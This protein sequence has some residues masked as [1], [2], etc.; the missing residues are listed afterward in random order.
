MAENTTTYTWTEWDKAMTEAFFKQQ[1]QDNTALNNA[2]NE[3]TQTGT[4]SKADE[5]AFDTFRGTYWTNASTVSQVTPATSTTSATPQPVITEVKPTTTA[6]QAIQDQA[7]AQAKLEAERTAQE[8]ARIAEQK[9]TA[10]AAVKTQEELATK[11]EINIKESDARQAALEAEKQA[12]IDKQKT[13]ALDAAEKAKE[14]TMSQLEKEQAAQK[15]KDDAAIL[16]AQEKQAVAEMQS[17]WAF[18]K[19]WLTFSSWAILQTQSIATKWATAI[20]QLKV[21]ASYNQAVIATKVWEIEATY[22][23]TIRDITNAATEQSISVRTEASNRIK[24]TQNNLLLNEKEKVKEIS[25]ILKEYK[26]EQYKLEDDIYVRTKEQSNKIIEQVEK[27]QTAMKTETTAAK[28]DINTL[29]NSWT[30]NTLTVAQQVEYAKKAGMSLSEVIKNVNWYINTE[31]YK[32]M[33]ALVWDTYIPTTAQSEAI[34][35]DTNRLM[36]IWKSMSEAVNIATNRVIKNSKEY[37]L[38]QKE[39][40]AKANYNIKQYT[41]VAT[42]K[43]TTTKANTSSSSSSTPAS[44]LNREIRLYEWRPV[45][46]IINEMTWKWSPVTDDKWTLIDAIDYTIDKKWNP[47]KKWSLNINGKS[48]S[49]TPFDRA[50]EAVKNN[51]TN[52]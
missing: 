25:T 44:A 40:A 33:K 12:L 14:N 21:Q 8:Q 27:L 30:W 47:V 45:V 39:E 17:N 36:S 41:K 13:E 3:Y 5:K 15:A 4:F 37:I 2:M 31:A 11:W 52:E 6:S 19:M 10:D 7:A 28:E 51:K 29:M 46:W 48:Q 43:T 50:R 23:K 1:Y 9:A 22:N 24:E 42:A 32:I 38:K 20:A 16:E 49:W 35:N 26:A 18:N 34:I